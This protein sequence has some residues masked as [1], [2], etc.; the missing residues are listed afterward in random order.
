MSAFAITQLMPSCEAFQTQ[1][2]YLYVCRPLVDRHADKSSRCANRMVFFLTKV[3]SLE[4]HMYTKR[5]SKFSVV[6]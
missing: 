6:F 2:P 5:Q 1:L 4:E 3:T